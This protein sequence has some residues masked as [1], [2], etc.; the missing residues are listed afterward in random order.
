MLIMP[1]DRTSHGAEVLAVRQGGAAQQVAAGLAFP[2]GMLIMPDDRTSHGAASSH[3]PSAQA[4][5]PA[6][7]PASIRSLN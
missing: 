6:A 5:T 1:D 7:G 2:N 3:V 4:P